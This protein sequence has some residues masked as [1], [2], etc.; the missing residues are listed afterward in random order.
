MTFIEWTKQQE[1]RNQMPTNPKTIKIRQ[2]R[3]RLT[4]MEAMLDEL[5]LL[6]EI[7]VE[8]AKAFRPSEKN[9]ASKD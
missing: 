4:R 8:E 7:I 6:K 3:N 1:S 2:E 5:L 9:H